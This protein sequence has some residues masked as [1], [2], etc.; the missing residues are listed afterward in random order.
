M[1][2]FVTMENVIS[3]L[4]KLGIDITSFTSYEQTIVFLLVNI[5]YLMTI[6]FVLYICYRLVLK[7]YNFFF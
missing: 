4:S 2:I 1:Y 6:F 3:I 5:F 7:L